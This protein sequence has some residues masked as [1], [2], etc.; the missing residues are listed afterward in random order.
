MGLG[1]DMLFVNGFGFP[2]WLCMLFSDVMGFLVVFR[3][4]VGGGVSW[5]C[6]VRGF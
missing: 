4:G 1:H 3:V 6:L 5:G 2:A